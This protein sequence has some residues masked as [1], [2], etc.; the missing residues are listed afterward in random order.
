MNNDIFFKPSKDDQL[1]KYDP[2]KIENQCIVFE[3]M[4][5]QRCFMF[6]DI[7]GL[8]VFRYVNPKRLKLLLNT[9]TDAVT[10]E[11]H[12]QKPSR[13]K[14]GPIWTTLAYWQTGHRWC[15][16]SSRI[17]VYNNHLK[18]CGHKPKTDKWQCS[19]YPFGTK[20]RSKL[21]SSLGFIQQ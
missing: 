13:E 16:P 17:P 8:N 20:L 6:L 18:M 15:D 10:A 9:N 5:W 4:E 1:L 19:I 3:L 14:Y 12:L 2:L 21:K 11:V 7:G